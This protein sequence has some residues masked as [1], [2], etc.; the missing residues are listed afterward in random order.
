MKQF[1]KYRIKAEIGVTD[2][3][4]VLGLALVAVAFFSA[5]AR[6]DIEHK[7]SFENKLS[8]IY[9]EAASD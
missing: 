7:A 8:G 1:W 2:A 3:L 9:Y 4:F 5:M 6:A